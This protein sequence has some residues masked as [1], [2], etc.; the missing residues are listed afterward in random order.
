MSS[1]LRQMLEVHEARARLR[2]GHTKF[3]ELLRTGELRSVKIGSRRLIPS[4]ALDE[5]M[6]RLLGQG[7][8]A[9]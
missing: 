5:Y 1:D 8:S 6:D 9:A 7:G 4:D 2:I 3:Y